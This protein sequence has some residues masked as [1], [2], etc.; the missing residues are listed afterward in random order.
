MCV[1]QS[2][3]K[4]REVFAASKMGFRDLVRALLTGDVDVDEVI[5][6]D[7]VII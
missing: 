1:P 4:K 6:V 7:E 2:S 3:G 5:H